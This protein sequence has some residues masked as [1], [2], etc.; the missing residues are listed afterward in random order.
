M[1]YNDEFCVNEKP[2][3]YI[4][5]VT[6]YVGVTLPSILLQRKYY[7]LDTIG[8][9]FFKIQNFIVTLAP[10]AKFMESEP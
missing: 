2:K 3:F 8:H 7:Q 4:S 5:S 9:P 1:E 6:I 10:C